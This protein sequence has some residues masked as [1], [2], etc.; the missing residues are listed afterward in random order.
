MVEEGWWCLD[1]DE[2]GFG[3]PKESYKA[4]VF[5]ELRVKSWY[6]FLTWWNC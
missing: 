5:S 4:L 2:L 3:L 1:W 6:L